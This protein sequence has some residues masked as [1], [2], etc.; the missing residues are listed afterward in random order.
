MLIAAEL[1]FI[2]LLSMMLFMVYKN[3]RTSAKKSLP[4]AKA[5]EYWNGKERRRH[6][7]FKEALELT[8]MI[9]R[10]PHLKHGRTV[11]ISEGGLKLVLAEKLATGTIM[12]LRIA[13]PNS[14]KNTEI[15]IEG[16]VVWSG[17]AKDEEG[18]GKRLFY[19]GIKFFAIPE[20][21]GTDLINYLRSLAK[22]SAV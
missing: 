12:D 11:N 15:E 3:E 6:V 4:R 22:D 14:K 2:V 16:D 8:Y 5:E 9:E 10:K 7:R 1:L 18:S 21:S 19:S 13:L 20:P 17:D